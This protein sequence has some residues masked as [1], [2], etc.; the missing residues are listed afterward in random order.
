LPPKK[1]T[2]E[3]DILNLGVASVDFSQELITGPMPFESPSCKDNEYY[4][5]EPLGFLSLQ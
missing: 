2:D 4:G 3:I 5:K 1:K